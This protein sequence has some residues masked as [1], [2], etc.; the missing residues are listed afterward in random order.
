[1]F[2]FPITFFK[3]SAPTY[4]P[5]EQ[6]SLRA[7]YD[8]SFGVFS[9]AAGT[10]AITDGVGVGCWKDRMGS[11][12]NMTQSNAS[13]K[14]IWHANSG[15]PYISFDGTN[16]YLYY[17]GSMI[18]GANVWTFAFRHQ[19]ASVT[20]VQI[21]FWLGDN[22]PSTGSGF[23]PAYQSGTQLAAQINNGAGNLNG[24]TVAVNDKLVNVAYTSSSTQFTWRVNSSTIGT[25][26]GYTQNFQNGFGLG[27]AFDTGSPLPYYGQVNVG[28]VVVY[29]VDIT[30]V[31]G[32]LALLE[33][34]LASKF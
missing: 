25:G 12:R 1:M 9:D 27:T 34:Y 16:D 6:G 14:P 15:N 26:A 29:S 2:T 24:P 30:G 20:G 3:S 23:L 8:P 4:G 10:V 18:S 17:S 7:W 33:T 22:Q 5:P 32:A 28:D 31:T 11:G 21:P 13:Y 19:I